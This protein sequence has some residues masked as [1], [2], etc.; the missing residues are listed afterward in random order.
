MAVA[1]PVLERKTEEREEKCEKRDYTSRMTEDELHN[2]QIPDIYAR[3]INPESK[4][5]DFKP[6]AVHE[7]T[8]VQQ[9]VPEENHIEQ[10]SAERVYL[11]ENARADADIFRADSV[12]NRKAEAVNI[13]SEPSML[14]E[15]SDED[16]EDLLPSR[17][18]MQ[19]SSQ[20]KKDLDEG[21]IS[22]KG[23]EKRISLSKR[24]KVIIAVV[25]S[26][27]IALFVLIIVNSAIISSANSNLGSLQASLDTAQNSYQSVVNEVSEYE[28]N[29]EGT[30]ESLAESYGMI[31]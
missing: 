3:L 14:A 24:D 27:I 22:N 11:V 7:Q 6:A 28:A 19:Y 13:Q 9:T 2:S 31:R 15:V 25:V 1:S 16:N 12:V 18:T 29:L 20:A 26:V 5:S 8:P 21:T 23:A 17:T 4:M 30:L 10:Q